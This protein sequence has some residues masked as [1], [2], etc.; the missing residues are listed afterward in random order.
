MMGML[1]GVKL[2][3][4]LIILICKYLFLSRGYRPV[5]CAKIGLKYQSRSKNNNLDNKT[6]FSYP[7]DYSALIIKHRFSRGLV[8]SK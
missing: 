2:L 6:R 5:S 3:T 7:E 1:V 4:F 8:Q